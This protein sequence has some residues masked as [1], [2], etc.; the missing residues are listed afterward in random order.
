MAEITALWQTDE[1]RRRQPTVRDEI[2]MGLDYYPSVL[3]ATVPALYDGVAD[4]F[5]ALLAYE[6]G[7]SPAPIVTPAPVAALALQI[8]DEMLDQIASRVAERLSAG[9]FG[10]QL[11]IVVTDTVR[12][13]VRTIVSD[14]SERLVRDEI[15]RI[16]NRD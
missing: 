12:D 7:E 1:V 4:D 10:D 15:D 9:R 11:K 14:T 2:R 5:A 3:F 13:T 6:Q 16:K 8:T